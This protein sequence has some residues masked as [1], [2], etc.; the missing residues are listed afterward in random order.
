MFIFLYL[1]NYK[2]HLYNYTS[3]TYYANVVKQENFSHVF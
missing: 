1:D 3:E 2:I